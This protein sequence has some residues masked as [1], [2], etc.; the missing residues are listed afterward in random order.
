MKI[1]ERIIRSRQGFELLKRLPKI[2]SVSFSTDVKNPEFSFLLFPN[3]ISSSAYK[4][5]L[6]FV[7]KSE[8]SSVIISSGQNESYSNEDILSIARQEVSPSKIIPHIPLFGYDEERLNKEIKLLH[9]DGIESVFLTEHPLDRPHKLRSSTK[10]DEHKNLSRLIR[11]AKKASP[12]MKIIISAS[13]RR[14]MTAEF[15][16]DIEDIKEQIDSGATSI[17]THHIYDNNMFF[18]FLEHCQNS[19]INIPISPN[20]LPIGNPKYLLDFCKNT[21]IDIPAKILMT[22]FREKGENAESVCIEDDQIEREAVEINAKQVRNL[23]DNGVSRIN[24]HIADNISFLDKV[25]RSV[26]IIK[27]QVRTR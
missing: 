26:D 6:D 11:I 22:I 3:N 25:L 1:A 17:I 12:N 24:V 23:I 10:S 27:D 8:S 15:M 13:P 18:D 19:G 2:H 4:N 16:A 14:N 21:E 5:S 20:I 9:E 7:R